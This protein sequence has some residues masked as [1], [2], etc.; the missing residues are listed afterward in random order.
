M[1][2]NVQNLSPLCDGT[3]SI[4][5]VITTFAAERR[6]RLEAGQ[7]VRDGPMGQ[8]LQYPIPLSTYLTW[9]YIVCCSNCYRLTQDAKL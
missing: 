2:I 3:V 4:R 1:F 7:G 9:A 6:S 5:A 8:R